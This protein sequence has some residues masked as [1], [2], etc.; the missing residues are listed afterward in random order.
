MTQLQLWE[1]YLSWKHP[2]NPVCVACGL[3][4]EPRDSP[5]P[6]CWISLPISF[7]WQEDR[8]SSCSC[9]RGKGRG[10]QE[11]MKGTV[12]KGLAHKV[13]GDAGLGGQSSSLLRSPCLKKGTESLAFII[14]P[15]KPFI[16]PSMN[17]RWNTTWKQSNENHD[18]TTYSILKT[19]GASFLLLGCFS[20][21]FISCYVPDLRENCKTWEQLRGGGAP[22]TGLSVAGESRLLK[23]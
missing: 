3:R 18:G 6:L 19:P 15:W 7:P 1:A 2:R 11:A 16:L 13:E 20:P 17:S 9:C 10:V 5:L 21:L 12:S 14:A 23:P 4:S 8:P 22:R